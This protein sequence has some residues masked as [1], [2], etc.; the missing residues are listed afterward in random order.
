MRKTI[1]MTIDSK[2]NEMLEEKLLDLNRDLYFKKR[3]MLSKSKL[4]EG[5]VLYALYMMNS[6]GVDIEL[7]NE[8][9]KMAYN[10]SL[11]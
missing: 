11:Y 10:Y 5:L 3:K 7:I 4:I 2:I 1:S 6:E 8:T 9:L